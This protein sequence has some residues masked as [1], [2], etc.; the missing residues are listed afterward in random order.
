LRAAFYAERANAVADH[1]KA[2]VEGWVSENLGDPAF[3]RSAIPALAM[4]MPPEESQNFLRNHAERDPEVV[5]AS[6]VRFDQW[7]QED[8]EAASGWLARNRDVS[9]FGEGAALISDSIAMEDPEGSA[10]WSALRPHSN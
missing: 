7:M 10:A 5:H 3:I 1:G 4:R 8:S 9:W 2:A 6:L